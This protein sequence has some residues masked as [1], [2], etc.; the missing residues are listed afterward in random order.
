MKH[1]AL[2]LVVLLAATGCYRHATTHTASR[3]AVHHHKTTV[4]KRAVHVTKTKAK[5]AATKSPSPQPQSHEG[6]WAGELD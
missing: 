1:R 5:P 4:A 3:P 6:V 2:A